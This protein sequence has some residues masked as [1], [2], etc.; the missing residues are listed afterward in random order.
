MVT[1]EYKRIERYLWGQIQSNVT[2]SKPT[3][4]QEAVCITQEI[5]EQA[6]RQGSFAK[7]TA[8]EKPWDNKRKWDNNSGNSS[9]Q[10]SQRKPKPSR[11]YTTT[12]AYKSGYT[13]NLPRCNRCSYHHN[14]PCNSVVRS[15]CK[16]PGHVA[17]NCRL[18]ASTQ[19]PPVAGA[20]P[21]ACYECG[22]SGH[23]KKDCP[24]LRNLGNTNNNARGRAFVIGARDA[25]E[26]PNIVTGTFLVNNRYVT[27]LFD[28]GA[29]RS[30]VSTEFCSLVGIEPTA[31]DCVYTIELANGKTKETRRILRNCPV[32]LSDRSF[33]IDL[34]PMELGSF[35]IVIGMD[36]LSKHHAEIVY[37][38]KK[39]RVPLPD[40]ET[41]V[42]QSEKN[43][44][45][46][47]II[48]CMRARRYLR[49]GC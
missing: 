46:L 41:L 7:K 34:L 10:H 36:W 44:D 6:V 49:K 18:N 23:F 28:T 48:T 22:D 13:G 40:G 42:I 31:L 15:K 8:S 2:A 37:F 3:T 9:N 25:R 30:F 11:A 24:K 17:K 33:E 43:V 27:I 21:R 4:I 47:R 20:K 14:G 19:P 45:K 32:T 5:T 39:V 35:D 16:R 1:P 26:D 38:E 29:H 12:V